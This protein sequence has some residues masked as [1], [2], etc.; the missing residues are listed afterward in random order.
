MQNRHKEILMRYFPAQTIDQ[1]A[2]YVSKYAIQLKFTAGRTTKLG[3][4]RP[5][6]KISNIHRIT[7][8]GNLNSW[9]LYLV[10]LH[11]FTHL[12]VWNKY[13]NR[14]NPHGPQWKQEFSSILKQLLFQNILPDDLVAPVSDFSNN[15]KATFASDQVLWK[16]LKKY[17]V[18]NGT[19]VFI[20]DIPLNSY[21][22]AANGKIF[23][24]EGKIRTRYRCLCMNNKRK[25]L[26]HP[27]AEITPVKG[28][29]KTENI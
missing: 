6:G 1:V 16:A 10:F 14:I 23:K 21:F 4:Y 28:E 7:V 24:K 3:D 8:N 27:M 25:Y 9:F 18:K 26:F 12:L 29:Y 15:V 22:A 11:E 20:E 17:D 2:G 13:R 5:P 19:E